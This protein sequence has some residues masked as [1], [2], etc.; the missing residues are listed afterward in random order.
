MNEDKAKYMHFKMTR[1]RNI[2]LHINKF[3]FE[4]VCNFAYLGF[5]LNENNL[6]WSEISEGVCKR[7][8]AY[9]ANPKILR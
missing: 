9:F 4:T 6:R 8:I 7:N 2:T 1:R 3:Y 5:P